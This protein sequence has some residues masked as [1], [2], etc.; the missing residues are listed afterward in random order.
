MTSTTTQITF[1][2]LPHSDALEA[3]IRE[4]VDWL[5]HF[6][7][8]LLGCHVLVEM[9]HRHAWGGRPF[10]VRL[11]ATIAGRPPIVI[12]RQPAPQA[13]EDAPLVVRDVFDT[14]RR[15]LQDTV[16]ERTDSHRQAG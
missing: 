15:R 6:H 8:D 2:G 5:M 13:S 16:H 12:S 1:R 7:A 10:H 3:L 9:P 4:R 14:L 11:E